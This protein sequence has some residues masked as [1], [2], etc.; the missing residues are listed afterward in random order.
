L[1]QK[2]IK[3]IQ[4]DKDFLI[5]KIIP[6]TDKN[7]LMIEIRH[8]ETQ[9][10]R[11]VLF[12]LNTLES[13]SPRQ[14]PENAWWMSM[15]GFKHPQIMYEEFGNDQDPS[16]KNFLIYNLESGNIIFRRENAQLIGIDK[17]SIFLEQENRIFAIDPEKFE[18]EELIENES[19]KS[20]LMNQKIFFPAQ[21]LEGDEYFTSTASFIKKITNSAPVRTIEYLEH[22]NHICLAYYIDEKNFLVNFLLVLNK[23][24]EI[25]FKNKLDSGLRGI[26]SES[27]FIM[28]NFLIF[29]SNKRD[30]SVYPLIDIRL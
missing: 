24:G 29:V 4:I 9:R 20:P 10:C 26:G 23:K 27:Y 12:D 8:P 13:F 25:L 11:Y 16:I 7:L 3:T 14:G 2:T 22:E 21:Y 15:V 6:D 5:W 1:S 17:Q 19:F 18:K 28:N 30:L